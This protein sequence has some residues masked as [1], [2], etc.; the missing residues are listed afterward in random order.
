[1]FYG[2]QRD[3][4]DAKQ[5]LGIF[6]TVI[7]QPAVV[8]AC[9]SR[10]QIRILHWAHKQAQRRIQKC[11]V[12]TLPVH[13]DNT[14]M[15]IPAAFAASFIGPWIGK[16]ATGFPAPHGTDKTEAK[17]GIDHMILVNP[18]HFLTVTQLYTR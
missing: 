10:G 15:R 13:V 12:D 7:R 16:G 18:K 1:M 9:A 5:P 6:A 3:H 8:G 4:G 11:R 2:L 14:G 17:P